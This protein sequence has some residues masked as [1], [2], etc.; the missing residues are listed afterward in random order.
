[1]KRLVFISIISFCAAMAAAQNAS[2]RP[3][4]VASNIKLAYNAS[5][6]YPGFRCGVEYPIRQTDVTRYRRNNKVKHYTQKRFASAELGFYHHPTFHDNVYLLLGWQMRKQRPRGFFT[7]FSPAIGYSRTFLS[8]ETYLVDDA[9]NISLV[10]LAG[11]DYVMV[12]IGGGFGY[13]FKTG[14]AAYFRA[15]WL[16]M[17]PSNNIVYMRPTL[18]LGIIWQPKH[19]LSARPTMNTKTKG[20]KA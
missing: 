19:F 17:F 13:Q 6:I 18:D 1:M 15:S 7:E 3:A 20:K 8:D 12:A 5:I 14:Y 4:L 16:S 9:G 10:K 11:Y 2:D